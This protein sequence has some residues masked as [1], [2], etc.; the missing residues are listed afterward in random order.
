MGRVIGGDAASA[1]RWP[2]AQI[3]LDID[4]NSLLDE[5]LGRSGPIEHRRK[6]QWLC[7]LHGGGDWRIGGGRGSSGGSKARRRARA[8]G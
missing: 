8:G 4:V 1:R 2:D 6:V 3:V 7:P 5:A